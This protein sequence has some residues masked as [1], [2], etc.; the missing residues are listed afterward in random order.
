MKSKEMM[1]N[2]LL[3]LAQS[4][5]FHC[6][7][8]HTLPASFDHKMKAID[9]SISTHCQTFHSSYGTNHFNV[10]QNIFVIYLNN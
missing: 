1:Y 5:N 8:T 6:R 10:K 3:V 7:S 9:D 2:K 4:N